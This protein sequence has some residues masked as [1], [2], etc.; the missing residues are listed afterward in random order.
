M[1]I[2]KEIELNELLKAIKRADGDVYLVSIQGDQ[3]NLKSPLSRYVALGE[4]IK[5]HG[6]ELEL[7]CQFKGDEPLFLNFFTNYPETL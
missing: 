3:Y 7:F 6:N 5:D 1:K 2:N 4:L